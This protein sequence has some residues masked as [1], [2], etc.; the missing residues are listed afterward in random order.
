MISFF[1]YFFLVSSVCAEDP[2][3]L[4]KNVLPHSYDLLVRTNVSRGIF[5][6]TG[7]VTIDLLVIEETSKIVLHAD[8]LY[9]DTSK[10][11][12]LRKPE[13]SGY[14]EMRIEDQSYNEEKQFFTII[15]E[16]NLLVERY[17]LTLHFDGTVRNDLYG[18][19]RSSYVVDNETRFVTL[20]FF[21]LSSIYKLLIFKNA[22][23]VD[24][25]HSIFSGAREKS[26]PV[27]GRAWI[28]SHFP[29]TLGTLRQR[30]RVVKHVSCVTKPHVSF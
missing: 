2:Y 29:T 4:P 24:R 12:L 13:D 16:E 15:F 17:F 11:A 21:Y 14:Q 8:G 6:F 7:K 26:I 30:N 27:H 28:Q 20:F 3:R 5:N 22:I 1:V 25:R 10:T 18:F 19:Y 9:I 23:Q